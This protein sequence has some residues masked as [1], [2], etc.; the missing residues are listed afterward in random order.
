MNMIDAVGLTKEFQV[1]QRR[2]GVAGA[3]RDLWQREYKRVAAVD[4]IDLQVQ[5]GEMV[6]Y[7]GA[8]GAGKSTTI[9][10]LSGI[11]VPT[12]G[13]LIVNG[14]V[15]HRERIDFCRRIG[16]VFG[17]RS[18]LWWDLA[19]SESFRLL[20]RVYQIPEA[21]YRRRLDRFVELLEMENFLHIPVRKLSLG[22]RMRCELTAALLHHPDLLFLDE[23]TIGLDVLAKERIRQFLMEINGELGTTVL[24]T[25]HDLSDIEALCSR[26]VMIDRGRILYDGSLTRLQQEYGGGRTLKVDFDQPV[27]MEELQE[28]FAGLPVAWETPE[29]RRA[30]AA[31]SIQEVSPATIMGVLIAR[32][33]VV[34]LAVQATPIEEIVK[35]IYRGA[36]VL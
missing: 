22:Q 15:P 26:V 14:F 21:D 29:P 32:F 8:N 4:H 27:T 9:K 31:F 16:V 7:I 34:D 25:T 33:P 20:S 30:L 6:G 2:E 3:F 23:P 13:R 19:V 10:M 28:A 17:Q 18:Q 36:V 24:L 11:L 12:S 1:F 35:A 5:R